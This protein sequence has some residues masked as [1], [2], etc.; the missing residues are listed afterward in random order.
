VFVVHHDLAPPMG[1]QV[2]INVAEFNI[3]LTQFFIQGLL[4]RF[5]KWLGP[6]N[7]VPTRCLLAFAVF[8]R[9]WTDF[10]YQVECEIVERHS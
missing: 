3:G 7:L 4:V 10:R 2:V 6:L 5:G 8:E 1:F 9:L